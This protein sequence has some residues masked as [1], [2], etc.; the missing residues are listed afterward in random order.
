[1]KKINY[2]L[3]LTAFLFSI[4]LCMVSCEME[5]DLEGLNTQ[6]DSTFKIE[7]ISFEQ[8]KSNDK[9]IQ[10]LNRF[11][12]KSVSKEIDNSKFSR[13]IYNSD[14]DF[15]INTNSVKHIINIETGMQSYNFSIIRDNPD[16]ENI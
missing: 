5:S 12:S 1:M 11:N 13:F 2:Y 4:L 8:L 15:V 6:Q 16:T 3:I 7:I 9:I 10:K 14:F